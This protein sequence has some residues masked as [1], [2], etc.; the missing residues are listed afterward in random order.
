M[1]QR[2][3]G[4]HTMY[5]HQTRFLPAPSGPFAKK[6]S[7]FQI[8]KRVI[9]QRSPRGRERVKDEILGKDLLVY[10]FKIHW[11]TN[12][13]TGRTF[14]FVF[15]FFSF[16]SLLLL[17]RNEKI[18]LFTNV[19]PNLTVLLSLVSQPSEPERKATL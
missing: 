2:P 4:E 7:K 17:L 9:L 1:S 11:R 10:S 15:V 12:Y 3:A 8:F 13:Y 19:V 5:F 14:L 6:E 18:K 16:T